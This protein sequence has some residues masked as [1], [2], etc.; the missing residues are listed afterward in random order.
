MARDRRLLLLLGTLVLSLEPAACTGP[1]NP[2]PEPPPVETGGAGGSGAATGTGGTP[3]GTGGTEVGG[4]GGVGGGGRGGA[5]GFGGDGVGGTGVGGSGGFGGGGTGGSGASGGSGGA[6]T[7]GSGG[8]AGGAGGGGKG[9]GAGAGGG[10]G[11]SAGGAG[12][13]GSSGAGGTGGGADAGPTADA[14]VDATADATVDGFGG[15]AGSGGSGGTGTGGSSGTGGTGTGGSSGGGAAGTGGSGVDGGIPPRDA[16]ADVSVDRD[17]G[18]SDA[19]VPPGKDA[20]AAGD[21]LGTDTTSGDRQDADARPC[22]NLE[23][24]QNKCTSGACQVDPCPNGGTTSVSG[25]VYDPANVNPLYNVIVYVPNAAVD[26]L[27]TGATCD[28]CG[29]VSGEPIT[30]TLTNAKGEFTLNDVPVADNLPIVVQV[31]KWRRQFTIPAPTTCVDTPITDRNLTRLPR[32]QAEGHLPRIALTTGGAGPLECWLR[33]IGISES[34]MT[35][36]AGQGRVN[37]YAGE[38]GTA[39]YNA[40][41]NG[42]VSFPAAP[43]FWSDVNSLKSYDIVLLSCE[44]IERPTNKSEAARKAMQEYTSA[45][46]RVFA[47]HFHNYWFQF[48]PAPF[49]SVAQWNAQPDPPNPF[50]AA[51]DMTFPKGQAL[52]EWLVNVGSATSLGNLTIVDGKNTVSRHVDGISQRWI[53]SDSP[54]TAQYLSFNTPVGEAAQCGR[55]VMSDIHS[56]S[57]DLSS[58]NT[59][60]PDGC[61]TTTLSD[62]EK[63]LEFMLFDLSGCLI[64]DNQPPSPPK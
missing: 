33:K 8:S 52:A 50:T 36:P 46:G 26:D 1:L 58:T 54:A 15:A 2:Q 45:G 20:D 18:A 13:A 22:K 37:F 6:G 57:M 40:S 10:T 14:S 60:F 16:S 4:S 29:Q 55:V 48:G 34:E 44:G 47:S 64:G 24:Y 35:P 62:Q 53:Y 21:T 56:S 61:Q 27:P 42:G 17:A 49:P 19:S 5:G 59:A 30:S 38:N 31:G 32:N 41:L 12:K 63:A 51:I 9:G 39:K 7:G 28:R 25:V 3:P 11:G 23:C 43:T